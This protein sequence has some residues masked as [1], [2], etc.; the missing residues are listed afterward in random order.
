MAPRL[1]AAN[2]RLI[3]RSPL[4]V[5][6]AVALVLAAPPL[7]QPSVE[8]AEARC[9]NAL[10]WPEDLTNKQA[11][12]AIVCVI[13]RRRSL[14]HQ[15]P[16]EERSAPRAAAT[17]HSRVMLEASCFSHRCPGE[18]DLTSRLH[19]TPYLP[20]ACSWGIGENLAWG[21][22]KKGSPKAI[23][24]AWMRSRGHRKIILTRSY[25]HIGVGVLPGRPGRAGYAG[26]ATYTANFG[27]K[28]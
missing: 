14:R 19:A 13:N 6:I 9:K 18:P 16:L 23:V 25:E 12:K 8:V 27:F 20:C 15:P 10:K 5:V 22:S 17:K 28:D 21:E 24:Q 11:R 2:R 3:A 1:A 26:A 7:V 4:I